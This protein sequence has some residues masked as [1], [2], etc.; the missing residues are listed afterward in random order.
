MV[1]DLADR[2]HVLDY[3]KTL[4]EGRPDDVLNDPRVV[5]AYVGAPAQAVDEKGRGLE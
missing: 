1:A 4:A 2:I 3:G 5:A